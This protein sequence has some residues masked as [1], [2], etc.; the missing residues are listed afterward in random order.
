MEDQSCQVGHLKVLVSEKVI[1]VDHIRAAIIGLAT[2]RSPPRKRRGATRRA[3]AGIQVAT[4]FGATK[5][6][7]DAFFSG[8]RKEK[9]RGRE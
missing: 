1:L 7:V 8:K 6:L 5:S 2:G 4:G 9:K 3:G